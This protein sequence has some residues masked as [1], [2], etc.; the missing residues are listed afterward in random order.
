MKE[1]TIP[2]VA[3]TDTQSV[4]VLRVWLANQQQHITMRTAVFEDP[5]AWGLFLCDLA[6]HIANAYNLEHGLNFEKTLARVRAGF[7]AE[8]DSPTDFPKGNIITN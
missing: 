2:D 3:K 1:L 8:M 7:N 5:A 6:R 4:E